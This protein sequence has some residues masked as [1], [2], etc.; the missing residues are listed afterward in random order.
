MALS[1]LMEHY[2]RGEFASVVDAAD[3][4]AGPPEARAAALRLAGQSAGKLAR[5][6][7]AAT[8]FLRCVEL[9][10]AISS[11]HAECLANA[12]LMLWRAG[13]PK[14]AALAW[15]CPWSCPILR[16]PG[17]GRRSGRGALW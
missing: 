10:P 7:L 8:Y 4:F 17:C 9:T 5:F 1:R 16:P 13:H 2:R 14:M 12:G 6:E 11:S 15:L 3:Q